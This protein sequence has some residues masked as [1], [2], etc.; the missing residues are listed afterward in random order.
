MPGKN[1]HSLSFSLQTRTHGYYG[2]ADYIIQRRNIHN[3]RIFQQFIPEGLE[4]PGNFRLVDPQH[5][6]I[7]GVKSKISLPQ[8]TDLSKNHHCTYDQTNRNRKL[9]DDKDLPGQACPR[10]VD[11]ASPQN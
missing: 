3:I 5:D 9:E 2:F 11:R 10:G 1:R 4:I 7:V 6:N 8:V